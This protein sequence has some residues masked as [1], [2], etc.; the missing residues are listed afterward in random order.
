MAVLRTSTAEF[1][2]S[3][4]GPVRRGRRPQIVAV[5]FDFDG[6]LID[7]DDLWWSKIDEVLISRSLP[8]SEE[9]ARR[10][11]LR[12]EDAIRGLGI[13]DEQ[14]V[15]SVAAEVRRI[16]EPL[17]EDESLM[18]GAVETISD[19][20]AA[21]VVLGVVSSSNST[22]LD[23]VLRRNGV[24]SHFAVLVGGDRVERAKPA[25]DGYRLAA[26]EIMVDPG[27]CCAV[28]DSSEGMEAAERAGMQ[29][30]HFKRE[31]GITDGSCAMLPGRAVVTSLHGLRDIVLGR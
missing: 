4:C 18:E 9:S 12:L 10:R 30:V 3:R 24:R 13:G 29:V 8:R 20:S 28:E 19:L 31:A 21:E 17:I 2:A 7:S 15:Q 1:L 23:R 6:V 5:L 14:I 26:Q 16:A 22:L 25:P 27:R 11:G